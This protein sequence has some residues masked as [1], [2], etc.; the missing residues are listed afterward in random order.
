MCHGLEGRIQKTYAGRIVTW[1]SSTINTRGPVQRPAYHRIWN[2]LFVPA[3]I[4]NKNRDELDD[5]WSIALSAAVGLDE[6]K[7]GSP[8]GSD[9]NNYEMTKTAPIYCNCTYY[10]SASC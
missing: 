7:I 2:S 9:I 5:F 8:S 4:V 10:H 6:E 3:P 1:V